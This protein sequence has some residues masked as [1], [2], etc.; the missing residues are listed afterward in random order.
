MLN[1]KFG[2]DKESNVKPASINLNTENGHIE[3]EAQRPVV[4]DVAK[5]FVNN[6]DNTK[7]SIFD[8]CHWYDYSAVADEGY[9]IGS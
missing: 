9:Q 8:G 7:L 5:L 3:G 1:L 2:Y 6:E 4:G